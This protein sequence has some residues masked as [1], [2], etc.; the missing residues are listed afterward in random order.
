MDDH[1]VP[2]GW[3]PMG[4]NTKG[5]GRADLQPEDARF[6]EI[7]STGPGAGPAS[8][9]RRILTGEQAKPFTPEN[10]LDGWQP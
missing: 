7:D 9:R 6:F 1:I 2:E 5:G 10:V 3:Y 8:A 4:Y